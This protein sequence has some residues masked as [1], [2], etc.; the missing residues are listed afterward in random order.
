MASAMSRCAIGGSLRPAMSGSSCPPIRASA[1]GPSIPAASLP[2]ME[3]EMTKPSYLLP[4]AA[5]LAGA[6][7]VAA[8]G[9]Y[10][11]NGRATPSVIV[12]A[13]GAIFPVVPG[14]RFAERLSAKSERRG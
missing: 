1:S 6:T 10:M 2:T 7:P 4:V 11:L 12:G 8:Q 13:D 14:P 3:F 9:I 5:L